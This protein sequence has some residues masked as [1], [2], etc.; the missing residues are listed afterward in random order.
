M[1]ARAQLPLQTFVEMDATFDAEGSV[2]T[3]LDTDTAEPDFRAYSSMEATDDGRLIYWGGGHGDYGGNDMDVYHVATNEWRQETEEENWKNRLQQCWAQEPDAPSDHPC[4]DPSHPARTAHLGQTWEVGGRQPTADR[5]ERSYRTGGT[6]SRFLTGRG[7]IGTRHSY[8]QYVWWPDKRWLILDYKDSLW[9]WDPVLGDADEAWMKIW[10]GE[11]NRGTAG[12]HY[13]N[14]AYDPRLATLVS[15]NAITEAAYVLRDG[16]WSKVADVP[17]DSYAAEVISEYH[18]ADDVHYV[19]YWSDLRTVDLKTGTVVDIRDSPPQAAGH[20]AMW[21]EYSPSREQMLVMGMDADDELGLWGFDPDADAWDRIPMSGEV[22]RADGSPITDADIRWDLLERD[23]VSGNF[24]FLAIRKG[25]GSQGVPLYA[26][27]LADDAGGPAPANPSPH[28]SYQ[29]VSLPIPR[30]AED[31]P[32]GNGKDFQIQWVESTGEV[33]IGFGDWNL[34]N[35]ESGINGNETIYAVDFETNS[36][37]VLQRHC[38]SD[39]HQDGW[40][41]VAIAYDSTRDEIW[42]FPGFGWTDGCGGGVSGETMAFDMETETW[43][44]TGHGQLY[45]HDDTGFGDYDPTT[46]KFYVAQRPG[47]DVIDPDPE[48]ADARRSVS[49]EGTDYRVGANQ[50]FLDVVGRGFYVT[51]TTPSEGPRLVRYDMDDESWLELSTMPAGTV[52]SNAY[53]SWDRNHR[54]ILAPIGKY[55]GEDESSGAVRVYHVDLALWQTNHFPDD[56]K[57]PF[58]NSVGYDQDSH[59][60][61]QMGAKTYPELQDV[62]ALEY[63]PVTT[64]RTES[65]ID[66]GGEPML[67]I[68]YNGEDDDG[69]GDVDCDDPQCADH[70]DCAED[71]VCDNGVDDD[72]DAMADCED[73]DCS[74]EPSCQSPGGDGGTR[75]D[76]GPRASDAGSGSD[77]TAIDGGCSCSYAPGA[78][79]G[80]GGSALVASFLGIVLSLLIVLRRRRSRRRPRAEEPVNADRAGATAP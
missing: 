67:E 40:D 19:G 25:H 35:D 58:G 77:P 10:E 48:A 22:R 52:V 53:A 28:P 31:Y 14:L 15:F 4:S 23:P 76:A 2:S 43:R 33:V 16:R 12:I 68:C 60:L 54:A 70:P 55:D 36:W 57:T 7:R 30:T 1:P 24:F 42:G 34:N 50:A 44:V 32:A 73:P 63:A 74:S 39:L 64:G 5:A 29:W 41:E 65:W 79:T 61:V 72:A 69:D 46:D 38:S 13:W 45:T 8:Q 80:G 51:D 78:H 6:S 3:E 62:F 11:T 26:F 18:E 66:P 21:I 49:N 75:A 20:S 47:V 56:G 17:Y 37:R 9:A 59:L 27:R 71:E